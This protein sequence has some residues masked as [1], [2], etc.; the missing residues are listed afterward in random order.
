M[1]VFASRHESQEPR[2]TVD[3]SRG[4]CVVN[5]LRRRVICSDSSC[6]RIFYMAGFAKESEGVLASHPRRRIVVFGVSALRVGGVLTRH[7]Y[8]SGLSH[9]RLGVRYPWVGVVSSAK[10]GMDGVR[11]GDCCHGRR[12]SCSILY[13]GARIHSGRR[14]RVPFSVSV[15]IGCVPPQQALDGTDALSWHASPVAR[16]VGLHGLGDTGPSCS[17]ASFWYPSFGSD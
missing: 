13:L 14:R 3:N 7:R 11:R 12:Y 5:G 6:S 17:S 16:A 2:T 9:F 4:P 10:R 1:M 8:Q 15:S